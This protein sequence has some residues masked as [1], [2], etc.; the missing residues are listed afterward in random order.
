MLKI[1]L[2]AIGALALGGCAYGDMLGATVSYGSPGYYGGYGHSNRYG[3]DSRCIRYD[4]YGRAYYVCN[5]YYGNYGYSPN[6]VVYYYPGYSYRQGY[7]YDRRGSRYHGRD[8]YNRY[9]GKK[10]Y[11]KKNKHRRG[12]DD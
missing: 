3:Y 8:L 9:Y 1:G 2:A 11:R 7:Y 5:S 10:H 4:R 6:R 12:R